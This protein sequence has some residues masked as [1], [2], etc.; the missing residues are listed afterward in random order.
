MSA[1]LGRSRY[2]ISYSIESIKFEKDTKTDVTKLDWR[3]KDG[4][5]TKTVAHFTVNIYNLGN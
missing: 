3:N 1:I 2:Y 4:G 5:T